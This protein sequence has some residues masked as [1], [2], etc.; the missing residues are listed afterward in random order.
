VSFVFSLFQE[1]QQPDDGSVFLFHQDRLLVRRD[2]EVVTVPLLSDVRG[3]GVSVPLLFTFGTSD[4]H[5]CFA[6]RE[7]TEVVTDIPGLTYVSIRSLFFTISDDQFMTVLCGLHVTRWFG[8]TLFCGKCGRATTLSE[9]EPA[10]ICGSC[11]HVQYP[12]ISPAIIVAVVNGDRI[13]LGHSGRFP[14]KLY[15]VIAGFV[16]PGETLEQCVLREVKE[17]TGI[18]IDSVTYFGSQPW[19]FPDSL[20]IGFTA[21]YTGGIIQVDGKELLHADWFRADELP[22]I[23]EGKSISRRLI[24]WF[25][26]QNKKGRP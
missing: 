24:N 5:I 26:E 11:G 9:T 20:M 18:D 4:G 14:E 21:R 7:S 16:D 8:N 19:P 2:G 13:L 17:E 6:G 15:S 12:K 23:P 22:A 1:K 3:A 10:K 25:I